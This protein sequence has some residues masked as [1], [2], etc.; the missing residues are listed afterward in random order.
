MLSFSNS[1]KLVLKGQY[2]DV[3]EN[4][5]LEGYRCKNEICDG[6]LLR[7]TGTVYDSSKR[8][9]I[10]FYCLL[11]CS[12]MALKTEIKNKWPTMCY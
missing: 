4:A 5:I 8:N 6:F 3:Q 9:I 1:V 7:T 10:I 2:E 12:R 11:I